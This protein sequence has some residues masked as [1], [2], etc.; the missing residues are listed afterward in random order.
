M[1]HKGNDVLIDSLKLLHEKGTKSFKLSAYANTNDPD[2]P[3]F[4][5][6]IRDMKE[7][8]EYKGAI[9]GKEKDERLRKA[10][11]FILTSRY[12]GIPMGGA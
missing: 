6:A 7:L 8:V 5:D 10:D 1:I 12:E 4:V 2:L 9:Y 11:M 3:L